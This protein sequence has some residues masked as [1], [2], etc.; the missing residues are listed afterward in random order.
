MCVCFTGIVYYFKGMYEC[1]YVFVLYC[2]IVLYYSYYYSI[3]VFHYVRRLER[4]WV[5]LKSGP[6]RVP[7]SR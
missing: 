3:T 5:I 4:I 7:L 2:I 1:V 6:N